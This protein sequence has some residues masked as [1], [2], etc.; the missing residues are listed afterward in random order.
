MAESDITSLST[1]ADGL[2]W[3]DLSRGAWT[4]IKTRVK[5]VET[6]IVTTQ[7]ADGVFIIDWGQGN[8]HKIVSAGYDI[9]SVSS[10]NGP[11]VGSVRTGTIEIHNTGGADLTVDATGSDTGLQNVLTVP[12]G[13]SRMLFITETGT[14]E[15]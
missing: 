6:Q 15:T 7:L 5:P 14:V 10:T 2:T 9:T 12:A 11:S 8:H 13:K 1:L 3:G 4:T